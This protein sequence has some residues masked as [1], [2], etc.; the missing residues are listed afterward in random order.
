[1]TRDVYKRQLYEFPAEPVRLDG[2]RVV[3]TP[4]VFVPKEQAD[5]VLEAHLD[6]I[7]IHYIID[8][9]EKILINSFDKAIPL[10]NP[11][12]PQSVSYTHL[13]L[14]LLSKMQRSLH[15]LE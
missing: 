12:T 5:W 15:A 9:C 10:S 2:N 6:C 14:P 11:N 4:A 13:L 1:M 8:G 7:E 3:V